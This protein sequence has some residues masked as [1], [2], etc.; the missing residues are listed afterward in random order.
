MYLVSTCRSLVMIFCFCFQ[1]FLTLCV[2]GSTNLSAPKVGF[3]SPVPQYPLYSA[4]VAEL[5][6]EMVDMYERFIC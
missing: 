6:A 2:P 4:C 1:S 5:G 3:M